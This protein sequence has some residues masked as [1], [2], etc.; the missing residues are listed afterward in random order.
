MIGNHVWASIPTD[1]GGSLIVL[2]PSPT[3]GF[4]GRMSATLGFLQ[5]EWR[6]FLVA[7]AIAAVIAPATRGSPAA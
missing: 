1:D 2:Y 7:G 5:S 6:Q 3:R 4:L